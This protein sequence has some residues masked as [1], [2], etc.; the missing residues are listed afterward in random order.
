M[1]TSFD[2]MFFPATMFAV[3][4]MVPVASREPGR[5][6]LPEP[7]SSVAV[8][9]SELNTPVYCLTYIGSVPS[10]AVAISR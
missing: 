8:L 2:P 6:V 7:S 3:A 10:S 4:E 9:V 1:R 5:I